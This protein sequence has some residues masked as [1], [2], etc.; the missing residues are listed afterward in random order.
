VLRILLKIFVYTLFFSLVVFFVKTTFFT[1]NNEI[2]EEKYIEPEVKKTNNLSEKL[3]KKLKE[4]I[5]LNSARKYYFIYIP[6]YFWD[7]LK[8]YERDIKTFITQKKIFSFISELRINFYETRKD[9]RWKMKNKNIKLFAPQKM[10]E[11]ETLN[12]FIHEFWHYVDLY[13]FDYDEKINK[14]LSEDFYKI[15]WNST[16]E[17]KAWL[18]QK[19]FVSGYAMTNKYEDFAE[20]FLYYIIDNK[21]FLKKTQKS[22]I[23]KKKY[24]FFRK[25]LFKKLFFGTKF[26]DNLIIKDYYRDMTKLK[27]NLKKFLQYLKK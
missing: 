15:S 23:L 24:E 11:A 22:E 7:F 14:D 2:I 25:N 12:V 18:T 9:R 5:N 21:D 10:W 4:K 27:L 6:S 13:Y 16:K 17:L 1:S 19:D 3:V 26:S 20:S 8:N